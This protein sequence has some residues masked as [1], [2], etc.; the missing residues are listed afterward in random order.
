[1][2]TLFSMLH[3]YSPECW[4]R[5]CFFYRIYVHL[6]SQLRAGR[7]RTTNYLGPYKGTQVASCLPFIL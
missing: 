5:A 2:T 7:A 3:N 4:L 1:M 6:M